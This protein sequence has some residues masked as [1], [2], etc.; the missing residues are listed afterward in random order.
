MNKRFPVPVFFVILAVL[1]GCAST[2]KVSRVDAATVVDLSGYWND[3]DIRIVC[4]GLIKD[5][6]DS[7]RVGMALAQMGKIP[8]FLV[9]PFR[10]ESDEH[11]DTSI[12]AD[13]MERAIFNSGRA[14]F[15]AGGATREALRAERLDQQG[16]ASEA[17]AKALANETGADFLLTGSVKTVVDRAGNTSTRT[18]FVGAEITNLETNQRLW[19]GSNSEIKKIIRQPGSKF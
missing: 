15:V 4:D 7:P 11:I 3:S 18:Y 8:V 19:L 10:N 16:N 6:L 5:C 12:I 1:S 13:T 17:T 9:G 2:P 14:D